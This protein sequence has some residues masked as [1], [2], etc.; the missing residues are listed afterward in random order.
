MQFQDKLK[1]LIDLFKNWLS[2]P[3]DSV[4]LEQWLEAADTLAHSFEFSDREQLYIDR[5]IEMYEEQFK[6]QI[7]KKALDTAIDIPS[8]EFL[9]ELI[10]RKQTEQRSAEWYAQMSTIISA[11]EIG[12]L[13]AAP[14][15]RAK[16]VL[17]KTLP[18]Q[19]RYQPLAVF[20]DR[21]AAF[22]WGIRFEPVAKQ[23]Y[24]YKYG[25][26]VK[27][28]GRLI[29]P[30]DTRC[31]ASPD[32]LV[33][34]C[35]KNERTG[36]L[37]E[38]KC[39]VTREIDGTVPKDYYAQMQLQLQVTG[40]KKCDYVEAGFTSKYN[41][42]PEK[43]G[44]ALYNGYIGLIRYAEMKGDQEFYYIYSPVNADSEWK[45]EIKDDEEIIEIIPWRLFQWSEQVITRSEEWWTSIKP[46]I[47]IF[48][49]DV[50]KAKRG[51]FVVPESTRPAKRPR[52]EK[53]MIMFNKLDENGKEI[54]PENVIVTPEPSV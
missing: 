23:L 4:Q 32:G 19:P 42:I 28:L 5:I 30:T 29:H 36:R 44:P 17:A 14:R 12:N 8:K 35:P 26:T 16:M 13:F 15:T 18:P 7:A 54:T 31:S 24:E 10:G 9:D 45:P 49:K 34:S 51:D 48:W 22:D 3:Q 11:S 37:I 50:E 41:N 39:P 53:C 43:V 20:S 2:D 33:Y 1:D 21:M 38:I 47:D 46:V 52:I 6:T 25:V 27:E 40:C